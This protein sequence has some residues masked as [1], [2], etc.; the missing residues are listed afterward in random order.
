M[1][2]RNCE[3]HLVA[4]H[5]NRFRLPK[6][7]NNHFKMGYDLELGANPELESN[8]ESHL[9]TRIVSLDGWP[10]LQGLT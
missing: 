9:Q 1:E 3:A 4:N 8:A 10:N 7:S 6:R 5:G 2:V